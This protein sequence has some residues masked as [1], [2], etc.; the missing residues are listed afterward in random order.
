MVAYV[1][2]HMR[3]LLEMALTLNM[4]GSCREELRGL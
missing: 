4:A 3:K 1:V 2:F